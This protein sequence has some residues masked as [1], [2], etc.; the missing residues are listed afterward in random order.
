MYTMSA[1]VFSPLQ[2]TGASV[3][4]HVFI[5]TRLDNRCSAL[6]YQQQVRKKNLQYLHNAAARVLS[7]TRKLDHSTSFLKQ[8]HWL[9]VCQIINFKIIM[10]TIISRNFSHLLLQVA[11]F[12][13]QTSSNSPQN[14]LQRSC[15]FSIHSQT[16]EHFTVKYP[17]YRSLWTFTRA[18]VKHFCSALL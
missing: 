2:A 16:L 12:D 17:S 6:W 9:P 15:L 7:K 5:T 13:L 18:C 10:L 14:I 11:I 4:N 1:V 8:L 3:L